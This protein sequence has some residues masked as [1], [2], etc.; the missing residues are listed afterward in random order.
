MLTGS[1]REAAGRDSPLSAGMQAAATHQH[2]LRGD[3]QAQGGAE[4]P[5]CRRGRFPGGVSRASEEGDWLK[6]RIV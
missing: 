6:V 1:N 3:R 2:G 5:A 4:N